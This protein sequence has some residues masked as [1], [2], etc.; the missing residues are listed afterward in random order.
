[1]EYQGSESSTFVKVVTTYPKFVKLFRDLIDNPFGR[2]SMKSRYGGGGVDQLRPPP[3][4][5]RFGRRSARSVGA[6]S[7]Y[8]GV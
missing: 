5:D 7:G 8:G 2:E 4:S 6:K 1:M 3:D